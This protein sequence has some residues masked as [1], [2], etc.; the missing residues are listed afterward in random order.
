MP[1][2]ARTSS[3]R[4]PNPLIDGSGS[5]DPIGEPLTYAWDDGQGHISTE[6]SPTFTLDEGEY[7]FSLTVTDPGDL[8]DTATVVI[9]VTK[10]RGKA[11]CNNP[12]S[13]KPECQSQ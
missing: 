5:S 3:S 1:V 10:D 7:I 12:N 2:R 11:Q 8:T 6:V 9:T 4:R 13:N